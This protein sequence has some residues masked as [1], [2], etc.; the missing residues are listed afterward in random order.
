M[1]YPLQPIAK[2]SAQ[3]R[4]LATREV[5]QEH[6]H[7]KFLRL[8]NTALKLDNPDEIQDAVFG[9]LGA[10][11]AKTGAGKIADPDCLQLA[12]ADRAFTNA[13]AA[14][15]IPGQVAALIYRSVE[16]NTGS[17]GLKSVACESIKAVNPEIA[18]LRQHQDPASDGAAAENKDIALK[19]A[20]EIAKVGGDPRDA[21]LSGTFAPGKIGDP[22]GA[23][24]TCDDQ[25]DAEG[26]IFTQK[27]L[28]PDVSEEEVL[29]AVDAAGLAKE[30]PAGDEQQA[31][32][33]ADEVE[34]V[35]EDNGK[36]DEAQRKDYQ[37]GNKN[38]D[39]RIVKIIK[40]VKIISN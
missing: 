35:V 33:E 5:P 6:S 21:I 27:L 9:L 1:D 24:N 34:E 32:D 25:D 38:N 15:D 12:T 31:D 4:S 30:V 14:G 28:V 36:I 17:V 29:A 18:A 39:V 3:H 26:C 10:A 22:T 20:V 23:G 2:R 13:K 19:L 40:I 37:G 16:R 7:E 8:T 11:A